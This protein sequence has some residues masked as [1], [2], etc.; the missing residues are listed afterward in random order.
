MDTITALSELHTELLHRSGIAPA[1][2]ASRGYKSESIKSRLGRQGFTRAQQTGPGLLIPIYNIDGIEEYKVFRPDSPRND[3]K[4]KPIKYENPTG[5]KVAID[6]HPDI[7]TRLLESNESFI[8]T[9]GI[10]KADAAVSK[11]LICVGLS[12]VYGWKDQHKFWTTVP[13]KGRLVY[14][15]FD[16]DM[17]T[18]P[19]VR[20]AVLSLK[21]FL[22]SKGAHVKIIY[23]P[24]T[25][26]QPKIGLDDFLAAD[27][28]TE[29]LLELA[30]DVP[31]TLTDTASEKQSRYQ[32]TDE[33]FWIL[34]TTPKGEIHPTL[35]S[36]FSAKI[37][38][39]FELETPSGTVRELEISCWLKDR[40]KIVY[41]D[42]TEYQRM[43][44]VTAQLGGSA[45]IHAGG[46]NRDEVRAAIQFNSPQ[47]ILIKTGISTLGWHKTDEEDFFVHAGGIIRGSD[48]V[49]INRNDPKA[50]ECINLSNEI[51]TPPIPDTLS[52]SVGDNTTNQ[53]A[54]E[55]DSCIAQPLDFVP[56]FEDNYIIRVPSDLKNYV[57]PKPLPMSEVRELAEAS[58]R[59]LDVADDFITYPLYAAIW[60]PVLGSA[61]FV[62]HLFGFTGSG[63]SEALA[64]MCQHY[65]PKL[66]ARNF[67]TN[68]SSTAN[69]IRSIS[70]SAR[71]VVLPVDDFVLTGSQTDIDRSNRMIED[72]FRSVGN[73]SGR[74]RCNRDGTSMETQRPASLI[75]STGE[76]RPSG[77]SINARTINIEICKNSIFVD[78]FSALPGMSELEIAIVEQRPKVLN[79]LQKDAKD[80]KFAA[81]MATFIAWV[82]VNKELIVSRCDEMAQDY[83]VDYNKI[84]S[85]KRTADAA[86]K[87]TAGFDIFLWFL[88]DAGFSEQEV[89]RLYNNALESISKQVGLQE[90]VQTQDD[91]VD[92]YIRLLTS[93]LATNRAYIHIEQEDMKKLAESYS[94]KPTYLGYVEQ[95]IWLQPAPLASTDIEP[96][97]S[98]SKTIGSGHS[99]TEG[100]DQAA[101]FETIYKPQGANVGWLRSD[102]IFIDPESSLA[103]VQKLA[104]EAGEP[105]LAIGVTA[106]GK[107]LAERQYIYTGK[108]RNVKRVNIDGKQTSAFHFQRNTFV[109]PGPITVQCFPDKKQ[110]RDDL[111]AKEK[112]GIFKYT[113]DFYRRYKEYINETYQQLLG[114]PT[115][116]LLARDKENFEA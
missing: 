9:E 55:V 26:G 44:W 63:K 112:E 86:A 103:T 69:H 108:D 14:I 25:D 110:F 49:Q 45:I 54:D 62:I 85:H 81:L 97:Q 19:T 52:D 64:I 7:R 40:E 84:C 4:G 30:S 34:N 6:V 65:G 8:I 93:A 107:R 71:N 77:K 23:L 22:E 116:D 61:D 68:W 13:I 92:R 42:A 72:V 12:G 96:S 89:N 75:V 80:G 29:K 35:I 37:T 38:A 94:L 53:H 24:H 27:E 32:A 99:D 47:P 87:L 31:P 98:E 91:V 90:I 113:D 10:R 46:R 73:S 111:L 3:R 48:F 15:A 36:N 59:F 33:G 78:E 51:P 95:R 102:S 16:S 50:L 88:S 21:S 67:P 106:L 17:Q 5:S 82:A 70:A 28:G 105:I 11:G 109:D 43:E 18:N 76:E 79:Q 56:S 83:R 100:V 60:Y 114:L 41:V 74:G 1:V 39:E 20:R 2:I 101:K 58:L 66:T 115:T 104:K 57:L